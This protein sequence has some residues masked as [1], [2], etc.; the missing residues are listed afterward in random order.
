MN[1][2]KVCQAYSSSNSLWASYEIIKGLI[3]KQTLSYDYIM[4]EATTHWPKASH[5][6]NLHQ[7]LMIKIPYQNHNIYSSTVLNYITT[8]NESIM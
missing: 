1:L 8:I 6:G 4:N 7:G 3:L 5:N 2:D